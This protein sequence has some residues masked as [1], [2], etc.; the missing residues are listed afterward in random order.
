MT[1]PKA[2]VWELE[3]HTRAKHQ[4]LRRYLNAWLPIIS[5]TS[6]EVLFLDSF[7]GPGIY[8]GGED[9]SPIIALKA[10]IEHAHL[11]VIKSKVHFVFFEAKKKRAAK[12]ES[13][14]QPL[15]SGLPQGST[16]VVLQGKYSELMTNALNELDA[17]RA[18]LAP[19][20]VFIDPF[21][22]S[23]LPITLVRRILAT[24]SCEVLINFMVGYAHRFISTPEF[25]KHLDD[26]FGVPDW[27]EAQA[28]VGH[29]RTD[30]LRR[31]YITQLT[32][33]GISGRAEYARAFSMLD[34]GKRPIYD[35]VFATN[36]VRG[37]DRMKD[38]LW[39]VD[40][41]T[42]ERF[43]DATSIG[44]ATLLDESTHHD[45]AL[46]SMLRSRFSGQTVSWPIV[47]DAIR[48][49]AYRILKRPL[50]NASKNPTSGISVI[51]ATRSLDDSA[52]IRFE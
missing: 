8:E 15:R 51:L 31:L 23:G 48:R 13:V 42:G 41:V 1:G 9:G 52:R 47:E 32:L 37:I 21:G 36:H 4:I 10:L 30:F 35:L 25:E 12:L 2:T 6:Q 45:E 14:V 46:I 18:K 33:P 3:P 19:S 40:G 16:A 50:L 17:K 22:V 26:V 39:K 20:L 24:R 27:R 49:S 5:S 11:H 38:A 29:E 43:S 28:L 34:G 44:Q 7:A